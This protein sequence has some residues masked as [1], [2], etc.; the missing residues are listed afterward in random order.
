[1]VG[2]LGWFVCAVPLFVVLPWLEPTGRALVVGIVLGAGAL[3]AAFD[4]FVRRD[5]A[6]EV[7]PEGIRAEGRLLPW[8]AVEDV[9]ER[10]VLGVRTIEID[11]V[12]V[13]LR[14]PVPRTGPVV[15]NPSFELDLRLLRTA[16]D[17]ART[18]DLLRSE[19]PTDPEVVIDLRP[20]ADT[21]A[22]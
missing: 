8:W 5:L 13:A 2:A 20:G 1:V 19:E 17:V 11:V 12:G 22:P 6:I 9:R 21:S 15:R 4:L 18:E 10:R 14:P 3:L 16:L 7:T